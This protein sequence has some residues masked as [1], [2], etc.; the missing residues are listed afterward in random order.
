MS[1]NAALYP[2]ELRPRG[3]DTRESFARNRKKTLVDIGFSEAWR[4]EGAD[5]QLARR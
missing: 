4:A 5:S 2:V 1:A 3:E